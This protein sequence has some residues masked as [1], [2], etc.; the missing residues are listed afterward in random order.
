MNRR[1][2]ILIQTLLLAILVANLGVVFLTHYFGADTN[3]LA[4]KDVLLIILLFLHVPYL[5]GMVWLDLLIF[6]PIGLL[7]AVHFFVIDEPLMT[8]IASLRQMII[9]FLFLTLGFLMVRSLTER[10]LHAWFKKAIYLLMF[11]SLVMY[12][13]FLFELIP[14]KT[15][16]ELK[17]LALTDYNIPFMFYD[18]ISGDLVRNV[19]TFLDPINLGHFLVFAIIYF[20]Y[21]KRTH[22]IFLLVLLLALVLTLSK[23][24]FLQLVLCVFILERNRFPCWLFYGGLLATLPLLYWA[25][26]HHAGIAAHLH[27]LKVAFTHFTFLGEGLGAVGNQAI[28]F[29]G[30]TA[31]DIF[32]TFIGSVVGQLGLL[33]IVLWLLPFGILFLRLY[34]YNWLQ[35]ILLTQLLIACISENSFNFLSI[36]S[37]MLFIGFYLNKE[38]AY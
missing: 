33:G 31:L 23:G 9:P 30:A 17:Q 18:G 38:D 26:M 10:Q 25:S 36:M 37:L 20:W 2:A 11:G 21:G 19:S 22:F 35:I 28:L 1:L 8:K 14:I 15:Y 16:A 7:L 5:R 12:S 3:Y 13:G 29:K 32:D 27:G 4:I 34:K 24:A 6:I